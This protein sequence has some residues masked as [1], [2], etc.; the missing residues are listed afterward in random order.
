MLISTHL[1][2]HFT[3]LAVTCWNFSVL[4][5]SSLLNPHPHPP[6]NK[7]ALWGLDF[8]K[9]P[10]LNRPVEW[11]CSR[12]RC[13]QSSSRLCGDAGGRVVAPSLVK[14]K[15][16]SNSHQIIFLHQHFA[17]K[18]GA[19]SELRLTFESFATDVTAVGAALPV[20]AGLVAE[21]GA[22][23]RE[24]LLTDVTAEGT[25]ARVRPL[26]LIQTGW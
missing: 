22:L 25:L 1:T 17:H 10:S 11:T 13:T 4:K 14:G 2:Y 3:F 19:T 6:H 16:N 24:A 5:L 26:V 7:R 21:K 12:S 18:L 23:L 20:L 9:A 15:R 8:K